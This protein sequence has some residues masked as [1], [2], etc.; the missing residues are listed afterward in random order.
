MVQF[1]QFQKIKGLLYYVA[2][3]E[4]VIPRMVFPEQHKINN[5]NEHIFS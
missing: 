2:I 1:S 4:K 5:G 3:R